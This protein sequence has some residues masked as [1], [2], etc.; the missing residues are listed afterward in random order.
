LSWDWGRGGENRNNERF[1]ALEQAV[2]ALESR[3]RLMKV[4][5]GSV[6]DKVNSVMGRL[7]ARIRKT[8]A[9]KRPESDDPEAP[10][11]VTTPAAM[12]GVHARLARHRR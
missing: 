6:L 3:S 10:Q 9:V 7:N 8:E 2:D 4:E 5:W 12:S 1:K 11:E